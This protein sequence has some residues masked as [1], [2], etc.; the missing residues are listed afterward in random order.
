MELSLNLQI[1]LYAVWYVAPYLWHILNEFFGEAEIGVLKTHNVMCQ[2][3]A[4]LLSL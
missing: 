4:D 1:R 2:L 3:P